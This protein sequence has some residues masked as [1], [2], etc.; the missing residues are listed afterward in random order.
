MAG[1]AVEIFEAYAP[2]G[3]PELYAAWASGSLHW[4]SAQQFGECIADARQMESGRIAEALFDL[5]VMAKDSPANY[6]K[7]SRMVKDWA[8]QLADEFVA[9]RRGSSRFYAYTLAWGHQAARD[10]LFRAVWKDLPTPGREARSAQF[11]CSERQY[12]RVREYVLDESKKL[13]SE[14]EARLDPLH[15]DA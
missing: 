3:M 10:G 7:H 12:V 8:Y 1:D 5:R 15:G 11:G 6:C 2:P 14:F 9:S 13:L 4:K